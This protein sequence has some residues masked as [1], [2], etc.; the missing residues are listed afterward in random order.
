MK[1]YNRP[2]YD[3]ERK[4]TARATRERARIREAFESFATPAPA[5]APKRCGCGC[6]TDA[7]G[8]CPE[9]SDPCQLRGW[10]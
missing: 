6:V 4:E 2:R 5:P 1:A 7:R 8:A 9:C 3:R 10:Q